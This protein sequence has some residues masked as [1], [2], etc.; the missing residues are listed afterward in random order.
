[1]QYKYYNDC[2]K[3]NRSIINIVFKVFSIVIILL[4]ARYVLT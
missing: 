4:L 2:V 1:M 3:C